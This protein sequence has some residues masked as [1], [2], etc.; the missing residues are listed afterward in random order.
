M[1]RSRIGKYIVAMMVV[2]FNPIF[3]ETLFR[4]FLVHNLA[5]VI[6]NIYLPILVGYIVFISLHLYQGIST[7]KPQTINYLFFVGFLFSPLGLIGAIGFHFAGDLLPILSLNDVI[8]NYKLIYRRD[9]GVRHLGVAEIG[10]EP[11]TK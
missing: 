2:L 4:G 7:I 3:E 11:T 8:K 6:E 9:R 1:P 10:M 5:I